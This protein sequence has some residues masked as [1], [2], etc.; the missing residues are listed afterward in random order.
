[1]AKEMTT[2][3]KTTYCIVVVGGLNWGLI[4]VFKRELFAD[5]LSLGIDLS[6]IIYAIIGL[7]AVYCV[8]GIVTMMQEESKK[9]S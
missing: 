9:S 3:D 8:Y 6:R 2:L 5:I 7:S 4:G 1:M